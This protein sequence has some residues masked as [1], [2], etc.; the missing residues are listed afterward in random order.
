MSELLTRLKGIFAEYD[1]IAKEKIGKLYSHY[2]SQ[3]STDQLDAH[4]HEHIEF[5]LFFDERDH[6]QLDDDSTEILPH[7][8][9]YDE[10]AD[11][12][13]SLSVDSLEQVLKEEYPCFG[14]LDFFTETCA[15]GTDMWGFNTTY[16]NT[17]RKL[18]YALAEFEVRHQGLECLVT[19]PYNVFDVLE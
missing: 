14:E 5:A 10:L 1:E 3:F 19:T 2:L 7:D 17:L 11:T 13:A 6:K 16:S 15:D 18:C 4:I 9:R 12:F 8:E